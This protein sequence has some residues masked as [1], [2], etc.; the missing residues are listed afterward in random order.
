MIDVEY[1]GMR[2]Q[3]GDNDTEYLGYFQ[4]ARQHRLVMK[5]CTACGLM[6]FPPGAACPWC[7]SLAW[8]WQE[9][10]GKGTIYSY[11][12]VYHAIQPGFRDVTPY[13][14]VVVELD[15]QKDVPNPGD[16]L[17]LVANLVDAQFRPE[18][19]A[20]V[21]IGKRVEVV[22]QDISEDFALPQFKLSDEPP[23]GPVW[24]F[25]L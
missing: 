13:P 25:P 2:I 9:V 21:A 1:R 23:P 11:E 6:R 18:A 24:Q 22:F 5:Q 12:I 19:E 7:Q 3:I 16:G 15:E 17:R 20:N 14:V 10:S 4:A 8:R